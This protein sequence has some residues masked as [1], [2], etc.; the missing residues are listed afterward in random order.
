MATANR[1]FWETVTVIGLVLAIFA[2]WSG[3]RWLANRQID[4]AEAE[5]QAVLEKRQEQLAADAV[6]VQRTAERWAEQLA[7][8]EAE[9]VFQSF[10]AGI[11][12][13]SAQRW[14]R[15]LGDARDRFERIP[16][17]EFA[18]LFTPGG[19]TIFTTNEA[20]FESGRVDERGEWAMASAEMR[21]RPSSQAGIT[22][23]AGPVAGGTILWIGY[24][25]ADAMKTGQPDAFR[26]SG[27]AVQPTETEPTTSP[28]PASP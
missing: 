5:Q 17:I 8:S 6:E 24:N 9:A 21:S 22:E 14:G 15:V 18:H 26:T 23:V 2:V 27:D 20:L 3:S 25:T 19:R 11:H 28:V 12:Y 4:A 10:A 16:R 13:A 7:R 1:V